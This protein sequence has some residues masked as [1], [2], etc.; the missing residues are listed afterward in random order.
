[1]VKLVF[2]NTEGASDHAFDIAEY[3]KQFLDGAL[4]SQTATRKRSKAIGVATRAMRRSIGRKDTKIDRLLE[5]EIHSDHIVEREGQR[6]ASK[7]RKAK[8]LR[9]LRIGLY[10]CKHTFFCEV[11]STSFDA[12]SSRV[13]RITDGLKCYSYFHR[14]VKKK[15]KHINVETLRS[16]RAIM[17]IQIGGIPC[18]FW[19]AP[20][21]GNG[22]AVA[23]NFKQLCKLSPQRPFLLFGDLNAEPEQVKKYG[24]PEECIIAPPQG[25]GTRINKKGT[26]IS[27]KI[28]D[29]ALTNVPKYRARC[30]PLYDSLEGFQIKVGTGSDHMPMILQY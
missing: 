3:H 25:D 20:S 8:L 19:H 15:L 28:L 5:R 13:G 30:R 27:N 14:G 29:Y 6:Y 9:D 4:R 1:M 18:L 2:W 26:R 7:V 12:Q 24:V 23:K 21:G 17:G 10:Q 11:T 22:Q 16:P